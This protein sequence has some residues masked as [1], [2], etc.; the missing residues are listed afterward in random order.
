MQ[1]S[2]T[3]KEVEECYLNG[4]EESEWIKIFLQVLSIQ[5]YFWHPSLTAITYREQI[6]DCRCERSPEDTARNCTSILFARTSIFATNICVCVWDWQTLPFISWKQDFHSGRLAADGSP[7][8][9]Y[10]L[11]RPKSILGTEHIP[12]SRP[13]IVRSR[14][15]RGSSKRRLCGVNPFVLTWCRLV[16]PTI[17]VARVQVTS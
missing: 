6:S 13:I 17:W 10:M 1:Y 11:V 12:W 8:Y 14:N 5:D 4:M 7:T 9:P 2:P 15:S 3:S 16:D